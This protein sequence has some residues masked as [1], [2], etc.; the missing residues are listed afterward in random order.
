LSDLNDRN[1][2]VDLQGSVC[3]V[4][5]QFAICVNKE[6]VR[7]IL[8]QN[9]FSSRKGRGCMAGYKFDLEALIGLYEKD[10]EVSASRRCPLST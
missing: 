8:L 6:T 9:G 7:R 3:V 5:E 4:E 2:K 1:E 10:L